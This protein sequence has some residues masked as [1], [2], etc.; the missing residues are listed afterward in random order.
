MEG[1]KVDLNTLEKDEL[2]S[3]ILVLQQIRKN[4]EDKFGVI[5]Y[6]NGETRPIEKGEEI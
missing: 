2:I 5:M 1:G 3:M 4:Y 6:A